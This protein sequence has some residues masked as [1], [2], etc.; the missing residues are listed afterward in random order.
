MGKQAPLI[1]FRRLLLS[2]ATDQG[3]HP[4]FSKSSLRGRV[5]PGLNNPKIMAYYYG[6]A[7]HNVINCSSMDWKTLR[8]FLGLVR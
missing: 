7:H 8:E 6:T 4:D 5:C 2:T 3:D 1:E